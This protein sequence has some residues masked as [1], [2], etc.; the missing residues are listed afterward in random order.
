M[1]AYK[2]RD[3]THLIESTKSK[4]ISKAKSQQIKCQMIK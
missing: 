4:K 2:T 1:P 3:P